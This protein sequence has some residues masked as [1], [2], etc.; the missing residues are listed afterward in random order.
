[1][2]ATPGRQNGTVVVDRF[3]PPTLEADMRRN[4]TTLAHAR[5]KCSEVKRG[6]LPRKVGRL[7]GAS[8]GDGCLMQQMRLMSAKFHSV[9]R[10][11]DLAGGRDAPE[12][13]RRCWTTVSASDERRSV[14]RL[15]HSALPGPGMLRCGCWRKEHSKRARISKGRWCHFRTS[16]KR[17]TDVQANFR[18]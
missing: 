10:S 15:E 3:K 8:D 11:H 18:L 13:H 4:A 1:M 14:K 9:W 6:L 17:R 7:F 5:S 16:Q 2:T 12:R